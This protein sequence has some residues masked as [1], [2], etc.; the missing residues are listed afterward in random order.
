MKY[1]NTIFTILT[2]NQGR[3]IGYLA[4]ILK[5]ENVKSQ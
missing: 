2:K 5:F 3:V 1:P 4:C